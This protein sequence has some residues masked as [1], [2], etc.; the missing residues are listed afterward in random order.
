VSA[1]DALSGIDFVQRWFDDAAPGTFGPDD[2]WQSGSHVIHV[3]AVDN[4]GNERT[5]SAPFTVLPPY[6]CRLARP[7]LTASPRRG[8]K[9]LVTGRVT[10]AHSTPLTL[11]IEH[12]RKG[13][14]RAYAKVRSRSGVS[15]TWRARLAL[16]SGRFR[17][18]AVTSRL[19]VWAGA[20]SPWRAVRVR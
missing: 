2:E 6:A 3:R 17:I 20:A 19:R 7:V 13:R 5:L 10:P 18:R 14:W 12:W 15:G 9:F 11:I 16:P 8:R 1:S 4:A